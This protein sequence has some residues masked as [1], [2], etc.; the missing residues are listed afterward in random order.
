MGQASEVTAK[1]L[2]TTE[3]ELLD[4]TN[5]LCG[6]ASQFG[7]VDPL[8]DA[9]AAMQQAVTALRSKKLEV[10]Q[11]R[12]EIALAALVRARKNMRQML[13]MSSGSSAS[14]CRS[15]DQQQRQK[16]RSPQEKKRQQEQQ[17][18]QLRSELDQLAGQ[19]RQWSEEVRSRSGGAELE[20][21]PQPQQPQGSQSSSQSSSSSPSTNLVDQQQQAMSQAERLQ[22]QLRDA[23]SASDVALAQMEDAA[24][25]IQE[26][27]DQLAGDQQDEAADAA[28]SA[29][30]RLAELSLHLKALNAADFSRQLVFAQQLAQRLADEQSGI[31]DAMQT[32]ANQTGGGGGS[33]GTAQQQRE[34]AGGAK[35]LEDLLARIGGAALDE[36]RPTQQ[37]IAELKAENPPAEITQTMNE[38]AEEFESGALSRAA[39]SADLATRSMGELAA[40][41]RHAR[42]QYAQPRLEELIE[43]EAQIAELLES[44]DPSDAPSRALTETKAADVQRQL[45]A[46]ARRD[47]QLAQALAQL[48]GGSTGGSGA[49]FQGGRGTPQDLGIVHSST[50]IGG[51]GL[52]EVSKVLQN[53]IQEVILASVKV[54]SDEAVPAEYRELVEQYYR[55]LSEDLR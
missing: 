18:A 5:E 28:R 43:V 13:S 45:L 34:V 52:R 48:N 8:E 15:F 23:K 14:Q 17:L 41:L 51:S 6:G 24:R 3:Q 19:Q 4:A 27:L 21:Q 9:A 25:S 55:T 40:A 20:R 11:A 46:L 7:P 44:V 38:A 32:A 1:R 10:G 36:D 42:Q 47:G 31:R 54:D 33:P 16:L 26:S 12:E 35:M 49:S 37:L 39:K 22:Q 50:V 30:D 53:R 29:A 2:A